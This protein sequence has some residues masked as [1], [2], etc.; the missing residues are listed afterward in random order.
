MILQIININLLFRIK[1]LYNLIIVKVQSNI[2]KNISEK[3][4]TFQDTLPA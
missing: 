2:K 3:H 1:I 4:F